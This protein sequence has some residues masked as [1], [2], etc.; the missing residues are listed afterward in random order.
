MLS[1]GS[2]RS[3]SNYVGG[4]RNQHIFALLL[5]FPLRPRRGMPHSFPRV[6]PT[7]ARYVLPMTMVGG[8]HIH[9]HLLRRLFRRRMFRRRPRVELHTFNVGSPCYLLW[10]RLCSRFF[11]CTP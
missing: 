2:D 1:T 6:A 10:R 9:R 4:G 11:G 5:V 7:G 8:I 3:N